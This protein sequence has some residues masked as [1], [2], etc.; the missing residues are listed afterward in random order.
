MLR[1]IEQTALGHFKYLPEKLGLAVTNY[2][3]LSIINCGLGS[4]MFNIV[5]GSLDSDVLKEDIQNVINQF[6]GQPF[7][8]W[9][10]LS[11]Y[12]SDLSAL[13][14]EA[15]LKIE[16]KEYAMILDLDLLENNTNQIELEIKQVVQQKDLQDFIT[17]L[18]PYDK[19]SRNFYEE[20]PI[21]ALA[22]CNDPHLVDQT[23]V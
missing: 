2:R 19:T 8:W 22:L 7:A 21:G 14:K 5:F 18:E 4:S 12:S 1:I 3:D 9:I 13:L 20:L 15:G 11:E 23:I 16:T 17:I 6:K 10:N